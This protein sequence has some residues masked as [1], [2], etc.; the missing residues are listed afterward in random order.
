MSQVVLAYHGDA[1]KRTTFNML[2]RFGRRA[3]PTLVCFSGIEVHVVLNVV[4]KSVLLRP[5][6]V[7]VDSWRLMY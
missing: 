4:K 3:V 7:V 5:Y 1:D 6:C 2:A